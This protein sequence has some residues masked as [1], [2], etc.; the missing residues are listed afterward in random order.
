MAK[1]KKKKNFKYMIEIE[2]VLKMYN[3]VNF[4]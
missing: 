3:F 4:S 2:G 1:A